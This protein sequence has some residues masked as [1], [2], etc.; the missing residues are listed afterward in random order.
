MKVLSYNTLAGFGDLDLRDGLLDFVE[1]VNPDVAFFSEG[2]LNDTNL[3]VVE[4]SI[5][6]LQSRGYD[7]AHNSDTTLIDRTDRTSFIGIVRRDLGRASVMS[8]GSYRGFIAHVTDP[9]SGRELKLGGSHM[10]D[11][12][13]EKRLAQVADLP[14]LD[15]FM[16]DLNAMHGDDTIAKAIRLFGPI[17]RRFAEQD[18]DFAINTNP[19]SKMMSMSQRLV[20]MADGR[21]LKALEASHGLKDSDPT[22]KPTIHGLVQID[23]ILHVDTLLPL[24]HTVHHEVN[25]SDH[26]PVSVNLESV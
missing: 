23:H 18:P 7:V 21:V 1:E 5:L 17:T 8:I 24:N 14:Q 26:K 9:I 20:R 6:G 4:G 16:G 3:S 2:Y 13:E 11:R 25:Y 12:T 22:H 15:V 19:V 10:D